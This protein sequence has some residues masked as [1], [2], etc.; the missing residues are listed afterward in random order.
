LSKYSGVAGVIAA[1]V[2][3]AAV[4]GCGSDTSGS[5]S[6]GAATAA[7]PV[8]FPKCASA[9]RLPSNNISGTVRTLL[10]QVP[11]SDAIK[12]MVPQFNKVYP[13]IKIQIEDANYDVI[14]D[15]LVASFQTSDPRYDLVPIDNPWM[16]DFASNYLENLSPQIACLPNYNYTDFAASLRRLGQFRG[17]VYGVPYYSYPLGLIR[18]S[19]LIKSAPQTLDELVSDV[20]K[21]TTS[22]TAGVAE[23]PQRGYKIEEDWG[24]WLLAAGGRPQAAD[25]KF[26]ID[27]PQARRALN[28]Y[29]DLYK[30]SAP[31][32]SL[33]WGFDETTR[34]ISTNKAAS[35]VSYALFLPFLN[36][37]GANKYTGKY[38]L[39]AMPGGR[40]VLGGWNWA[41]PK[42]SKQKQ[43]AWA[44]I[45]WITS[46][47]ADRQRTIV[48]G[49]PT[50]NSVMSDPT[51]WSKGY[52]K[53]FYMTYQQILNNAV[54][55]CVGFNCEEAI[56]KIGTQLNAAVAGITSVNSALSKA[57]ADATAAWGGQ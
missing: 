3:A 57:Q 51:V 20:Q 26:T 55:L 37:K 8:A 5:H 19:D 39:S 30:H 43:A 16:A 15:K 31:K 6:A 35:Y 29:I 48:G 40:G 50:R 28:I 47:T 33:N 46:H 14:R 17:G 41:I 1:T 2:M 45:S 12:K 7:Q 32:N 25:G 52:G 27:T 21:A 54:P 23:Q 44:W 11:D 53:S 9:N 13:N 34:A 18:R 4:T 49:A 38:Q 56:Q 22:T 24:N 36:A 42:N 10:E